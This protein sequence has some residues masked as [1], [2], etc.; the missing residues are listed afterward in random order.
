[1]PLE[2]E[3][4][5]P[6]IRELGERGARS[7]LVGMVVNLFQALTKSMAGFFRH[8]FALIA[9]DLESAAAD[10]VT[11]LVVYLGLKIAVRPDK[12][13]P[14][15]NDKAEPIAVLVVGLSLRWLPQPLPLRVS[16]VLSPSIH[17]PPL[18]TLVVLAG[19]LIVKELL[20]R[21]VNSVGEPIG[22]LA[23]RNDAWHHP[24]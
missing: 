4:G 17:L 10:V 16:M 7:T 24:K 14:Y 19:L 2:R 5:N 8:S 15:G 12:N 3:A 20:F 6:A 11:G 18:C 21:H 1:M 22:S 9:H 13:H 23:V